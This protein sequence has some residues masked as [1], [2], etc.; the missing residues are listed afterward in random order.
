MSEREPR[1]KVG[2]KVRAK[3]TKRVGRVKKVFSE[4]EPPRWKYLIEGWD[5]TY[6]E[7]DFEPVIE[8]EARRELKVAE[9]S[10]KELGEPRDLIGET[11]MVAP[12]GLEAR[13]RVKMG[14]S[15][16]IVVP[17]P[18]RESLGLKRGDIVQVVLWK[19]ERRKGRNGGGNRQ[20]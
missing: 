11:G 5:F 12:S 14:T 20:E 9:E 13:F 4:G 17:E 18:D 7:E 6:D 15:G 3:S 16:R 1:F 2:Q 10:M 19:V 8:E